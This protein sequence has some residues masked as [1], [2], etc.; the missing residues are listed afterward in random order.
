MKSVELVLQLLYNCH[1]EDGVPKYKKLEKF[2]LEK[3]IIGYL[4]DA[5]FIFKGLTYGR[6]PQSRINISYK[7]HW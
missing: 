3:Y 4:Y 6:T 1:N 2:K 7:I 5:S